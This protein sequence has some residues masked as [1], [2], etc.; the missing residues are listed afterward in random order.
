MPIFKKEGQYIKLAKSVI[1]NPPRYFFFNLIKFSK[2]KRFLQ[3]LTKNDTF[4][5]FLVKNLKNQGFLT[6]K[7][8]TGRQKFV[9]VKKIGEKSAKAYIFEPKKYWTLISKIK[10]K[11]ENSLGGGGGRDLFSAPYDFKVPFQNLIF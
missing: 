3:I 11:Y 1:K 10:T 9:A 6:S 7:G 2:K 8:S 5:N 4:L